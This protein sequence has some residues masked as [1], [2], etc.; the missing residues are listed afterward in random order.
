MGVEL[1][2]SLPAAKE[3]YDRAS[4]V[5]GYDLLEVCASGPKETLDSTAISQPAIYVSSLAAIE[6][7]RSTGGI[8][9]PFALDPVPLVCLP[10]VLLFIP[11]LML[12]K[13]AQKALDLR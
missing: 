1:A 5:L 3:L 4:D 10:L 11:D 8:G 6:K 2:A 12:S 9:F 13:W 7:L